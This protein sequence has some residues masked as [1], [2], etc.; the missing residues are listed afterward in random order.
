MNYTEDF[1]PDAC[2]RCGDC[3]HQCPVMK[4]PIEV[5][6]GEIVRLIDGKKTRHV[7]SRCTSCFSCN[8]ICPEGANPAN[9]VLSRWYEKYLEEGMPARELYFTPHSPVNFRTY[10]KD[11]M[12]DDEK[13]LVEEWDDDSPCEEIFYPGCNIITVPYLTMSRLFEGFTIRGALDLCCGEMYFRKGHYDQV[14]AIARK[15]TE[16]FKKMGLKRMYI[17]CTAGR[18]IFTTVLPSFGAE[19]DF[20]VKHILPWIYE[21]LESGDLTV[22]DPLNMRVT[23]HDSCHGKAFGDEYMDLPRKILE[24]IGA[25]VLE[26]EYIRDMKLCCGIGGGFSHPSSY[27]PLKITLSTFRSLKSSHKPG[28]DAVAVYCAGCLQMMSVGQLLNPARNLPIYHLIELV[29]MAIGEKP[30]RR[31]K[32]RGIHFIAGLMRHQAP[33]L[34]SGKR[35]TMNGIDEIVEKRG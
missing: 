1:K 12:P 9:L 18:N 11:H 4:L 33:L 16:H 13:K 22:T 23:V 27:N 29:Q 7:L 31:I 2:T 26:Q 30:E 8:V 34:L 32:T 24:R 10:V 19:F 17:A 21:R 20:E 14:R 5:A 3:F 35:Y 25:T 15:L 28:A 6:K